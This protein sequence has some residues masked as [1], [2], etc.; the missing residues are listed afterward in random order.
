M[1]NGDL[2]LPS[3]LLMPDRQV[4]FDIADQKDVIPPD[5]WLL[6]TTFLRR[7]QARVL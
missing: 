1:Q 6:Y 3:F 7:D 4:F 2:L 5:L